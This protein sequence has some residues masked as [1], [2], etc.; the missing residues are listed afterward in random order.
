MKFREDFSLD[1]ESPKG[2]T[3]VTF[4][5]FKDDKF[6]EFEIYGADKP[7]K[8]GGRQSKG[9]DDRDALRRF[10]AKFSPDVRVF[11]FNGI[12]FDLPLLWEILNGTEP[13]PKKMTFR[14]SEYGSKIIEDKD[15]WPEKGEYSFTHVD[16]REL[17][18]LKYN[19]KRTAASLGFTRLLDYEFNHDLVVEDK[20][21]RKAIKEYCRV[22]NLATKHIAN[23][24]ITIGELE[25]R[26]TLMELY[27][28]DL[29]TLGRPRVAKKVIAT[30]YKEKYG[31]NPYSEKK[32]KWGGS[33]DQVYPRLKRF[34][35]KFENLVVDRYKFTQEDFRQMFAK[36]W[37]FERAGFVGKDEKFSIKFHHAGLDYSMGEGGLHDEGGSLYLYSDKDWVIYNIDGS[38]YYPRIIQR[39]GFNPSYLPCFSEILGEKTDFR[40]GCKAKKDSK[41]KRIAKSTKI[42]INAAFGQLGDI[43]SPFFD[44][45]PFVATTINGQLGLLQ[46]VDWLTKIEA[47]YKVLQANTDGIC[48]VVHREDVWKVEK[49]CKYWEERFEIDLDIDELG[50]FWKLNTNS[51]LELDKD[52]KVIKGVKDFA[53]EIDPNKAMPFIVINEAIVKY[54]SEGIP[55]AETIRS[56]KDIRKF[57]CI[58]SGASSFS[59]NPTQSYFEIDGAGKAPVQRNGRYYRAIRG[60]RYSRTFLKRDSNVQFPGADSVRLLLD[61]EDLNTD[62]YPDLDYNW[63]INQAV[64]VLKPL[65]D[66]TKPLRPAY[67]LDL[68]S[69]EAEVDD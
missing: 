33:A 46:I 19:L 4:C 36:V 21:T 9:K 25:D 24:K 27:D 40:V 66:A 56:E 57:T 41:S 12:K 62:A 65:C 37:N 11:T 1:I 23:H 63:Y 42:V 31:I 10:M 53:T 22:D 5:R 26:E 55:I 69:K 28:L 60:G 8:E 49:V 17:L 29:Y 34:K 18:N 2:Y 16:L 52:L 32:Q 43:F 20:D 39:F 61:I 59:D 3:L 64:E 6:F 15:F 50:A 45:E 35:L 14:V 54:C 67:F 58:V 7:K 30:L 51:Y 68:Q 44:I 13:D 48:I 38:S 47:R